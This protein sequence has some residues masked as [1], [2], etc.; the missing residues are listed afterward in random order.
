MWLQGQLLALLS[1]LAVSAFTRGGKYV[2][3]HVA[4]VACAVEC[5]V[6]MTLGMNERKGHVQERVAGQDG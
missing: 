2:S 4:L 5:G 3:L 6:C 1:F